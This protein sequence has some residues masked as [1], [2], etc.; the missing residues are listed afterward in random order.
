MERVSEEDVVIDE[1]RLVGK[2]KQR[3]VGE[4]GVSACGEG[5]TTEGGMNPDNESSQCKA[6]E[7]EIGMGKK[8]VWLHEGEERIDDVCVC[9][10][11]VCV[12]AS[13]CACVIRTE[14]KINQGHLQCSALCHHLPGLL[15]DML[16]SLMCRSLQGKVGR[17]CRGRVC[18]C[19]CCCVRDG[20]CLSGWEKNAL[21]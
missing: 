4:W 5:T 3:R 16:P 21:N 9:S 10:V 19:V 20:A 12:C 17:E 13:L 18:K 1:E 15:L 6:S 2:R 7:K 8:R 14:G 11:C